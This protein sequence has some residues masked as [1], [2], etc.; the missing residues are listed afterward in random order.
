MLGQRN[1]VTWDDY[2][3][4]PGRP[5]SDPTRKGYERKFNIALVAVDYPDHDF[6][7]TVAENS[8]VFTNPQAAAN[9]LS[10]KDVPA[11]F[12]DLLIKPYDLNRDYTLHKYWMEDSDGHFG[13]DLTAFGA[14]HMPS[15]SYQYGVDD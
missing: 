9:S 5:W 10:R 6:V 8:T 2:V 4:P 1:L 3:R 7:I 11:F 15:N 14:Y 13:V 12:R